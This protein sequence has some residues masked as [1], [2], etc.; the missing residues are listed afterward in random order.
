MSIV[1]SRKE[2]PL[3]QENSHEAVLASE[4][5]AP[6]G[7]FRNLSGQGPGADR[8]FFCLGGR[9]L[10]SGCPEP[11]GNTAAFHEAG[12]LTRHCPERAE[13]LRNLEP[14]EVQPP[15]LQQHVTRTIGEW[16]CSR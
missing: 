14:A 10:R 6:D 7:S 12:L 8:T 11:P 3:L 15:S 2:M 1:G 4:S 13:K 9:M 5:T 16:S